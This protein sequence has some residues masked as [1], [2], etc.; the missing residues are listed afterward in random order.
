MARPLQRERTVGR[1]C[2]AL[3]RPL[4]PYRA[5]SARSRLVTNSEQHSADLASSTNRSIIPAFP[6]IWLQGGHHGR[7]TTSRGIPLS[8][9]SACSRY[10]SRNRWTYSSTHFV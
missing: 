9:A 2:P 10:A 4:H 8:P 6:E 1:L 3:E 5:L 7:K